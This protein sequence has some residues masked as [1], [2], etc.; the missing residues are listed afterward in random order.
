M[1]PQRHEHRNI[2]SIVLIKDKLIKEEK[3]PVTDG[4][5]DLDPVTRRPALKSPRPNAPN[6]AE[7]PELL[8]G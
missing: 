2:E 3:R 1:K 5:S 7:H 4:S 6:H 8:A